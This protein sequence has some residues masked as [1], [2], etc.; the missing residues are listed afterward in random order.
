MSKLLFLVLTGCLAAILPVSTADASDTI[1]LRQPPQRMIVR[2][3]HRREESVKE[4]PA[5]ISPRSV[6][7]AL[8]ERIRSMFNRAIDPSTGRVTVAS[9][10]K[11]G[12]G[13]LVGQFD[14]IDRNKDGSLTFSEVKGFLDA[15]SPIAKPA[16][17]GSVQMIE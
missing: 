7:G 13:Y 9:A 3:P 6:R 16:S 15:Q 4:T 2:L 1:V 12:V 8:D 17:E 10:D 14:E 5:P 11:A